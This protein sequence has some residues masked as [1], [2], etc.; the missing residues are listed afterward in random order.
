MFSAVLFAQ[1]L[2]A[3][4]TIELA[5]LDWKEVCIY[6]TMHVFPS[7]YE[8][9]R[10]LN[11]FQPDIIFVELSQF[12]DALV[13]AKASRTIRPDAAIVGFAQ[14]CDE[15]HARLAMQAG[16]LVVLSS[17]LTDEKF[18]QGVEQA[19]RKARPA[20]QENVLAFLPAKA[21]SGS[22]TIALNVAG[23]LARD[24]E[25][26]VLA[27][28][29]DLRSG[30]FSVLLKF[31]AEY[32][33]LDALEN[34]ALLDGTLW[35]RIVVEAQGLD[36]LATPRPTRATVVSWASY[37]QLLQFVLSRYETIVVDLPE[38]IND[39][40]LEIVRRARRVFIVTT[41]ELPSLV[42]ARQRCQELRDRGLVNDRI[43]VIVNRWSKNEIRISDVERFL[44]MPVVTVF[45]ND[46][47][48]V[49][50]A[51]QQGRL[52]GEKSELGRSFSD[53]ASKL[54]GVRSPVSPPKSNLAF[55][56]SLLPRKVHAVR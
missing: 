51:T 6:K 47:Q 35:S 12:E 22:T 16:V 40:T 44:E 8:L 50:R 45:Q 7:P 34:A 9:T 23:A 48:C 2:V 37:H 15:E 26:K 13:L 14:V 10:L 5:A 38:V 11:S 32:S 42:L 3:A 20:G 25:Q 49:R 52:I 31:S 28:E 55:L 21:G 56:D 46:Y 29:A 43:S 4:R 18:Q 33:I 54:A 24:L 39:A 27:I 19:M 36:L 17:P 53:F 41:P 30:L 1:D